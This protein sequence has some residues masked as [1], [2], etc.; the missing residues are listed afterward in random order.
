MKKISVVVPCYNEQKSI[1]L[2]YQTIKNIFE[3]ELSEYDYDLILADDYSKDNTREIIRNL[4]KKDRHVKAVFN[5]SN[6]GF[7]R[8]VFSALQE[9]EG[10]AVFLVF[11][12]MQDP[13]ELLP[14]F[15]K[16]WEN[17]SKVVIGQKTASDE[18]RF[19]NFMRKMYY[20]VI[21]SLSDKP[22]IEE[23]NGFGLYDH[24]FID[25]L[26]GI[27]DIQ[28]YLKTV[29][30]EYAPDYDKVLYHH[31]KSERGKSNFSLYK[32]YDF[33]MEGITSSTKKLMRMATFIGA[34]LGVISAIYAIS[35]VVRKILFRDMFP[36]GLASIMVGVY[37]LGAIQLFFIGILGEYMLSINVRT[38]RKPRVVVDERINFEDNNLENTDSEV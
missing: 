27:G 19:M 23:F 11:G 3:K 36:I 37:L 38:M 28:P 9:A 24:K 13:P 15:V 5:M 22:Q 4:C 10:N 6:F 21:R 8:N 34:G 14:E 29:V 30:S 1:E 25:V 17:G 20:R 31:Q 18:A 12:D 32:N 33:A 16:K 7:S 26:R 35:V 2:M